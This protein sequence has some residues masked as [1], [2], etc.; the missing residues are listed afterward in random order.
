ML[1]NKE[2]F[3]PTLYDDE[4]I[5][6]YAY[7][8]NRQFEGNRPTWFEAKIYMDQIEDATDYIDFGNEVERSFMHTELGVN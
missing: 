7:L 3:D 1:T 8:E 5:F 6:K 4:T 2:R